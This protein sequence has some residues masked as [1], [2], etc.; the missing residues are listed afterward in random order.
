QDALDFDMSGDGC[1]DNCGNL[2]SCR[3]AVNGT[4]SK[5]LSRGNEISSV[6][7]G[8][9]ELYCTESPDSLDSVEN[10]A[11]SKLQ[12]ALD[13]FCAEEGR[14]A[15]G[16]GLNAYC[17]ADMF[18]RFDVGTASQ[19][20]KEWRCY[21]KES[22]DFGMS[23]EGCVDDCGNVTSCLGAVNGTST[24]HLTRDAQVRELIQKKKSVGCTQ[25]GET[26]SEA[27]AP[28]REPE[29]PAGVPGTETA[30]KGLKVPPRVPGTG[31]LQHVLDSQCMVEVAKLCI[32]DESKCDYAVARRVGSRWD[33]Y[34]YGA[35]DD[36]HSTDA[37]TDDCGNA[38]TCPGVPKAGDTSVTE[39]SD[40]NAMAQQF[41]EA[42]CKM[43]EKQELR[44]I[45]AHQQ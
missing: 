21:V 14:R 35:L 45:H 1:V 3:G 20:N 43:S 37:C 28:G 26:G 32:A 16:Q 42:T 44:G 30:G 23:G 19:Q 25:Q 6:I 9:K 15:C 31:H 34:L 24:T 8:D 27:P 29:V 39:N 2:I 33:C 18:A 41:S 36:S 38:I 11:L 10:P 12:G 22:L 5:H 4:S 40:L 17:N 13:G 7:L